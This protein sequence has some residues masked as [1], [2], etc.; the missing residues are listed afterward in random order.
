MSVSKHKSQSGRKIPKSTNTQLN[1]KLS[2]LKKRDYIVGDSDDI[3]HID[4]LS[5]WSEMKTCTRFLTVAA[6][7]ERSNR[8][9]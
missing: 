8:Y 2:R 3:M 4:W 7:N 5:E 9:G 1:D 6:K